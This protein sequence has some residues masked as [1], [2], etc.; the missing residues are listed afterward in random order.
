VSDYLPFVVIGLTT[1]AIY[2]LSAIGFVL[3]YRTSGIFNFAYG[4]LAAVAVFF[5]YWLNVDHGV[6]WPIA[7][8][9]SVFV[10]GPIMGLLMEL[11][12]KRLSLTTTALRIVG[13]IGIVLIVEALGALKYTSGVQF[14]YF[15]GRTPAFRIAGVTVLWSQVVIF[16]I[17]L[18]TAILLFLWLRYTLNGMSMRAVVDDPSLLDLTGVSPTRVRRGSWI[19]GCTLAAL[20]GVLVAQGNALDAT[21]VTLLILAGLGAAAVGYFSNL[22][23]TYL[24]GTLIGVTAA[25]LLKVAASHPFLQSIPIS[26]PYLVLL[27]APLVLPRR[28]LVTVGES[29][30]RRLTPWKAPGRVR[31]VTGLVLVA[32]L[33]FVPSLVGVHLVAYTNGFT[34]VVMLLSLGLL[35]KTSNQ[36]SLCHLT[37]AAIGAAVFSQLRVDHGWPWFLA[38]FVA[39]LIVVPFGALVAI[40]AIRL[41]GVFLAL[42]TL[43]FGVVV[44]RMFFPTPIMFGATSA[45][46]SMPRPSF[47]TDDTAYYYVV[48]AFAVL[49]SVVMVAIH[50]GRLGRMLRGMGDS[51]T[52]LRTLGLSV[53][54]TRVIVFCI[55]SFFAGLSGVLFGCLITR[56]GSATFPPEE[57]LTLLAV[58]AIAPF[59]EPWYALVGAIGL[60]IPTYFSDLSGHLTL[61]LSVVFGV[62][63]VLVAIQGGTA[64]APMRVR[65]LFERFR[66]DPL[67][68]LSESVA[69]AGSAPIVQPQH[70]AAGLEVSDLEVRFGGLVAVSGLSLKAPTGRITGLIGPNGAGKTTTFN[71]CTGLNRPTH[72]TIVLH[73]R[74]VSGLTAPARSRLGLGRTFQNMEL[75]E[76]LSV[77][78]NV[79]L[80]R[81]AGV[82]GG[83]L[84]GRLF[85]TATQTTEVRLAAAEAMEL[86]G[87]TDLAGSNAGEL[88]TGERRLVELARCLAGTFDMLLLDEPSAGLDR[89]ETYQFGQILTT[90]VER[91]GVGIL[92][93]EHDIE[94]VMNIC[95]YV[96][97]LDFGRLIFEGSPRAVASSPIVKTA[98]LGESS[99]D[100]EL[101]EEQ[102]LAAEQPAGER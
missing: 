22:P 17:G 40:P 53:N 69:G 61:W 74:D 87:I 86:C 36:V 58:L 72:G 44:S 48:L 21:F 20:S 65:R 3:T 4:S 93:V 31:V 57:S 2:G 9:L 49:T 82:A 7:F 92:L 6:S 27:F 52:A 19:I 39:A 64:P 18:C 33:L 5:F 23:L 63:A 88:S 25:L 13:T 99:D 54:A 95:S 73:G 41:P 35:V 68:G 101:V 11:L 51:P 77:F 85:S 97:V 62:F 84:L 26:L 47:A 98:Y 1:G 8:V 90:V 78:E 89:E 10:L 59:V 55:S 79:A 91:R 66:V 80:G 75:F 24:G 45:G 83:R 100:I 30:R 67:R 29:V 34:K 43:G 94:L 81:E 76:S 46:R 70:A 16:A 60:V 50:E 15:L 102:V 12:A 42:A 32:V 96:Y 14:P 71:S 38:L 28:K 37:F 56:V